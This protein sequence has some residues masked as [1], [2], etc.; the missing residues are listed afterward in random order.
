MQTITKTTSQDCFGRGNL[1]LLIVDNKFGRAIVSLQ[2]AQLLSYQRKQDDK[3]FLWLSDSAV[4]ET[5][6]AIRG[7]VPIC[8]PWF[9]PKEGKAQHGF[10]R[11]L[12]WRLC[13]DG[14]PEQVKF[15]FVA[16]ADDSRHDFDWDFSA[17][18]AMSFTDQ[19]QLSLTVVNESA[20]PM[21]LSWALHSYHPVTD[22]DKT[23]LSGLDQRTFLDNTHQ[24]RRS[25][26]SGPV[27]FSG[28]VD[29]AYLQVGKSQRIDG[30]FE[31]SASNA[32][33][34]VVWNPGAELSNRMADLSG[35]R[36]FVC[37]ER[38]D[39]LDDERRLVPFEPYSSTVT[40]RTL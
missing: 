40:V 5:G 10:A 18:I 27:E 31:V 12:V 25:I 17:T 39:V 23:T 20:E 9:G 26:Q 16:R 14:N 2:G 3:E 35:Y 13:D 6:K 34:A 7:G 15:E 36:G 32:Q 30:H 8:L 11:N 21:P 37:L 4:F 33:S 38:G 19:L 29:R 24:R 1:E 22:I 28:E